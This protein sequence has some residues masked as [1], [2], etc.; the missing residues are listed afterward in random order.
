MAS[1]DDLTRQVDELS[2]MVAI[3]S[4][5]WCV[6]DEYQRIYCLSVTEE[7]WKIT[8]QVHL[9]E[10]YPSQSSPEFQIHT[11]WLRDEERVILESGL[12]S[13]CR[14]NEGEC[15]LHLLAEKVRQHLQERDDS[16]SGSEVE[17]S[18]ETWISLDGNGS[19]SDTPSGAPSVP[20]AEIEIPEILHGEPFTDRKSTF[21]GHIAFP[22]MSVKQVKMV[23][24]KLYENRK[25]A[26]ATHNIMAYRIELPSTGAFLQDC[27]D[28]GETAAAARVLHLLQ[29]VDA[30]NVVVIVSRWFG[31]ILLHLDRFKHISNAA[32]NMLELTGFI[33]NKQDKV[34]KKTVKS[35][36]K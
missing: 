33:E 28:D 9:P 26:N 30:R 10:T 2:A 23:L 7:E 15:V 22:V 11:P 1:E 6:V 27:D 32:R 12:L 29:I 31:G 3:Y 34:K 20:E 21:Q 24:R 8:L 13:I 25:I 16:K 5:D 18:L 35:K 36:R 4:S 17:S 14:E 19:D